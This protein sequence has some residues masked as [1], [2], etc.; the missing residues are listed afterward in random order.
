M[1]LSRPCC[2]HV[3]RGLGQQRGTEFLAQAPELKGLGVIKKFAPPPSA[4]PPNKL[5]MITLRDPKQDLW[6]PTVIRQMAHY[7]TG[8]YAEVI[9]ENRRRTRGLRISR[10]PLYSSVSFGRGKK[11]YARQRPSTNVVGMEP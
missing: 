3:R 5:A 1:P 6:W 7:E 2:E 8:Q 11:I 10:P 9:S 4:D